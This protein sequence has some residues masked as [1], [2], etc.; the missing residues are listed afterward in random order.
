MTV[1][2]VLCLFVAFLLIDSLAMKP[3][4]PAMSP[5]GRTWRVTPTLEWAGALAQDGGQ[6]LIDPRAELT[7]PRD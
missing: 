3:K 2:L 7:E 6:M 4:L 1:I 5:G